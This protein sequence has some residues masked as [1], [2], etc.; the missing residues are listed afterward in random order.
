MA[1]RRAFTLVE[2]L[3]VI[4]I[5]GV[6]VALLLPAVQAARESARRMNCQSN[7]KN[8]ALAGLNFESSFRKLPPA[9]RDREGPKWTDTVKPPPLAR[10]NGLSLILPYF[11]QGATFAGIDYQWDWDNTNPTGNETHTKQQLGGIL[12]CPSGSASRERF[13][14]TDYLV[15]NRVEI[16]SK[17]PNTK[18]DPPGGSIKKLITAGLVDS[19]GGAKNYDRRW[20]GAMQVDLYD[21]TPPNDMT[22]AGVKP[23]RNVRLARVTDGTSKT[24]MFTESV[25]K[26]EI[27]T[28]DG[29]L[30]ENSS[31]NNEFRWASQ[32][33]Y[34]TL[35]FYCRDQQLINCTNRYRP[36]S[37]HAAGLNIAL[38]DG[39]VR[40]HTEE[41]DPDAFISLITMAAGESAGD[42]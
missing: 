35:Q 2:L 9:A 15:I 22:A 32:E 6:L 37:T 14:I 18:Y 40:F 21:Q 26:P 1:T 23:R 5:I 38:L 36:F 8:L 24:M 11:E 28:I 13:H 29:S 16:A 19:R 20:D 4:A 30:G 7:L 17:S 27:L 25:G 41:I 10:H 31:A 34:S 3:V 42:F 12:I 33:T 39:S